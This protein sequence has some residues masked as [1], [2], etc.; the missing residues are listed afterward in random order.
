MVGESVIKTKKGTGISHGFSLLEIIVILAF[1]GIVLAM[2]ATYARKVVDENTRQKEANAVVQDIAGVLQFLNA[3]S[4]PATVDGKSENITNPFYQQP[5]TPVSDAPGDK[6]L[7]GIRNNPLY[8]IHLGNDSSHSGLQPT[9]MNSVVSPYIARNY[10]AGVTSP[11]ANVISTVIAGKTIYNQF[12]SWNEGWVRAFFTD[13]GCVNKGDVYFNQQFL[14][15][16]ENPILRNSEISISRIDLIN[17]KGS[18]SQDPAPDPAIIIPLGIERVDVFIRF[19]PADGNYARIEQYVTPLMNAFREKKITP[20]ATSVFVTQIVGSD[21]LEANW[22][23]TQKDGN[24]C[25]Y[26][27]TTSCEN[28]L[29]LSEL[30]NYLDKLKKGTVYGIRLSFDGKGDFLRTDGLNSA[31]K[32]CWSVENNA[33][34]P[35][36]RAPSEDLLALHKRNQP[37]ELASMQLRDVVLQ[38]PKVKIGKNED[39]E[40]YTAPLTRYVAFSNRGDSP[41]PVFV[42]KKKNSD[43]SESDENEVC[44]SESTSQVCAPA[45]PLTPAELSQEGNGAILLPVQT[46]PVAEGKDRNKVTLYPRLSASVSSFIAGIPTS[47]EYNLTFSDISPVFGDQANNLNPGGTKS[48]GN[49]TINRIGGAILQVTQDTSDK[50]QW[51]IASMVPVEGIAAPAGKGNINQYWQFYNPSWLSV[52]VS[53]WCS[54]V[55]QQPSQSPKPQP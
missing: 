55:P 39:Y 11:I 8:K 7:T 53:T 3:D 14:S 42:Q 37:E 29:T 51:H 46:C 38:G 54:S 10:S 31:S 45:K 49:L 4:I 35:C 25:R 21:I 19:T 24:Y 2:V 36:L 9:N 20:N 28:L 27:T 47:N 12:L 13:S 17:Q 50:P 34:G 32:V 22:E 44:S 26:G 1:I 30:P 15:C 6:N 33:T 16:N 52:V 18:T 48:L 40:Y 23:L 41:S 43:G 5:G